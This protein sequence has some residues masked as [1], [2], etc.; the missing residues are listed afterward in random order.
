[1]AVHELNIPEDEFLRMSLRQLNILIDLN[2]NHRIGILN[3]V[4]AKILAPSQDGDIEI[5]EVDSFSDVF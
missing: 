4:A 3:Q 2:R 5:I 1:M